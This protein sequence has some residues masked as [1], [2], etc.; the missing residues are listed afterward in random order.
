M[1]FESVGLWFSFLVISGVFL[2]SGCYQTHKV[3][4]DVFV[5]LFLKEMGRV[6]IIIV[7]FKM[8]RSTQRG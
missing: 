5:L 7:V 4:W 2:A 1:V 8:K 6:G 3:R